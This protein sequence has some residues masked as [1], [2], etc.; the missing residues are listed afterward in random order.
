MPLSAHAPN[1]TDFDATPAFACASALASSI[2]FA[3]AYPNCPAL[4]TSAVTLEKATVDEI[5]T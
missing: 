5:G 1:C 4:P 3:A 2:A